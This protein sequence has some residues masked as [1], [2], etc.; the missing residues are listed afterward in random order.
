[1][2][3]YLL[4][5]SA[6]LLA[7]VS[8][9]RGLFGRLAA[10]PAAGEAPGDAGLRAQAV[11]RAEAAYFAVL[12]AVRGAAGAGPGPEQAAVGRLEAGAAGVVAPLS[13]RQQRRAATARAAGLASAHEVIGL[14]VVAG[15]LTILHDDEQGDLQEA[16]P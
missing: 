4:S 1:M 7:E 13:R 15:I 8:A 10:S 9:Q 16:S 2:N 12:T 14:S 5:P 11:L 3:A 6:A